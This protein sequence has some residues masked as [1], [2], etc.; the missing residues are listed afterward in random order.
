MFFLVRGGDHLKNEQI[1]ANQLADQLSGVRFLP[2]NIKKY[3][4]AKTA[5]ISLFVFELIIF[6]LDLMKNLEYIK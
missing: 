6:H 2:F 3:Q 4:G 1:S 5:S